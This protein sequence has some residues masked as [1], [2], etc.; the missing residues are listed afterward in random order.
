MNKMTKRRLSHKSGRNAEKIAYLERYYGAKNLERRLS[1]GIDDL[2]LTS[3]QAKSP[4]YDGMPHSH[5][6]ER[7]LSDLM[8]KLDKEFSRLFKQQ[9]KAVAIRQE[10]E[11]CINV[12]EKEK[13]RMVLWL[14]YIKF[15][16]WEK[17]A[18]ELNYD[19]KYILKLH[20]TALEHLKIKS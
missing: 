6:T 5:D 16:S 17:V 13:E 18:V 11:A 1:E 14:R 4:K 2:Y 12:L 8:A 15:Y 10:I 9:K 3:M 20:G 19:F 7:D